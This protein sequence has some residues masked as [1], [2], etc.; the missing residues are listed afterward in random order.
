MDFPFQ[1]ACPA[2]PVEA[3]RL[4]RSGG[5]TSLSFD[6]FD[7]TLLRFCTDP[8]GVF[9]RAFSLLPVA[10]SGPAR[11]ETFVQHRQIAEFAAR[12][13]AKKR[14]GSPEVDIAEIYA[15]FPRHL[16]GIDDAETLIDAEFRA[17]CDL[18]HANPEIV[19]LL[20]EAR[21]QGV[22]VGFLSDTYWSGKQ[23][24]GLLNL[25]LPPDAGWDFLYASADHRTGKTES[26]FPVYLRQRKLTAAQALHL[27]DDPESDVRAAQR[28]GIRALHLP[29]CDAALAAQFRSEDAVFHAACAAAAPACRLDH[30]ARTRRRAAAARLA[31]DDPAFAYGGRVVGPLLDVFD[32]FAVQRAAE[33]AVASGRTVR[34]AFVARDG[35]LPH[36]IW[37]ACGHA[38][39]AYVEI[40]RRTALLCAADDPEALGGFFR[41]METI[42]LASAR[43]FLKR[44]TPRLRKYFAKCPDGIADGARF[45]DDLPGLLSKTDLAEIAR[46]GRQRLLAHL[47]S[48][49]PDFSACSD[50]ILVDLGYSGTVQKALRRAF[51]RASLRMRLHGVYLITVDEDL[52]EIGDGDT[53]CGLISGSVLPPLTRHALLSNIA[54]LEQVC[55]APVGSVEGYDAAGRARREADPRP[56]E[57]LA[58][59]GRIRAG[60]VAYA[61]AAR[62]VDEPPPP[63]ATAAAWAAAILARALLL[64]SD[65]EIDLFS[66]MRHDIN[67]GTRDTASMADA[68]AARARLTALPL[69]AAFS[70][71][72][73][74]MWLAGSMAQVSPLH[75]ALYALAALGQLPDA[76][77]A[78]A[79]VAEVSVIV[80]E[81]D[82]GHSFPVRVQAVRGAFGEL[83]VR[84]PVTRRLGASLVAFPA[85]M[86]PPR[87]R[88]CGLTLSSGDSVRQAVASAKAARLPLD[89]LS[90]EGMTLAADGSYAGQDGDGF[91]AAR[92]PPPTAEIGVLT[93][94]VMPED[95]LRLL[96]A[97]PDAS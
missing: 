64:P 72:M 33:I 27:G 43:R 77:L 38:R 5:V 47:R 50:L 32:A 10:G 3:R 31:T 73:P 16:F 9:E 1:E 68:G 60:A 95:G 6:V 56:P 96:A 25:A 58:L 39:A 29:Q 11:A 34:T 17:E 83:R 15:R 87:G 44:E 76:A 78:D 26:L 89:V 65:A 12:K 49:I 51:D 37:K 28:C 71:S 69:P 48:E 82:S 35:F 94:A 8:A 61:A 53:A 79:P 24:A 74:P 92:V 2:A 80:G 40:N 93:L 75:G 84:V 88:V 22:S 45:A 23:L 97:M 70:P 52:E 59:G 85:A 13:E 57:Q 30:G 4:I 21:T 91:L 36:E 42:D 63:D 62:A 90:A 55:T 46:D 41:R 14:R 18:C 86:L 19:R 7:T 54:L 81:A 20:V 67:L 66:A